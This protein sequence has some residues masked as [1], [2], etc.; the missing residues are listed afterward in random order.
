MK[1]LHSITQSVSYDFVF[2]NFYS[3]VVCTRTQKFKYRSLDLFVHFLKIQ[4]II[5]KEYFS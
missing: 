2:C 4:I 3:L 5:L 1:Y